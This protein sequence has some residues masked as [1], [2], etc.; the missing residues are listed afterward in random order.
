[1]ELD[2]VATDTSERAFESYF[3][4]GSLEPINDVA[5]VDPD[6]VPLAE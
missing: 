6:V 4:S 1:M 2:A 5:T 3:K